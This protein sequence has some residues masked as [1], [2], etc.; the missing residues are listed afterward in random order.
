MLFRSFLAFLLPYVEQKPLYD[1]LNLNKY[2]LG[3]A[4][5][6]AG[7]L[8]ARGRELLQTPIDSYVCPS[9]K[10]EPINRRRGWYASW[11]SSLTPYISSG[12]A[13][14]SATSNYVGVA[15]AGPGWDDGVLLARWPSPGIV[16]VVKFANITDGTA[17]GFAVGERR[18]EERRVG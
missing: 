9:A 5:N 3:D 17:N 13:W 8:G 4:L 18:S 12:S 11:N 16:A 1:Q 10:S 7:P 15:G 14:Y 6:L 2:A